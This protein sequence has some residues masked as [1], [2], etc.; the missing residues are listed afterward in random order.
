MRNGFQVFLED[1]T[2]FRP[3]QP[4]QLTQHAELYPCQLLFLQPFV[5]LSFERTVQ[6]RKANA[7]G[8]FLIHSSTSIK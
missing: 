1:L 8:Y 2:L 4:P 6:K 5:K 3:F 7:N